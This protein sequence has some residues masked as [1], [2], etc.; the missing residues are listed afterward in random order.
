[1][2]T[3]TFTLNGK[4]TR[5]TVDEDRSLLWVLRDDLGL[6]GTKFG[7]GLAVCGAC[8]VLVDNEPARACGTP[9]R[10]I[11][12]RHVVTIEGLARDG[13]L[14]PVQEA[15]VG[16]V[17]FQCGYCTPGMIMGA[18]GLLL[19]NPSPT[20]RD[21]ATE[22]DGHLCRCAAHTRI[23]AAVQTAAATMKGATR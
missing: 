5:M 16:H 14:H 8:T 3:L 7:C 12:G 20:T 21:I 23:V 15:F 9:M 11:Q 2:S 19:K 6:T 4:P 18:Y 1:M 13:T 22:L 17:G 10:D